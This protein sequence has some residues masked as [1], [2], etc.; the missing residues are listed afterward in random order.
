MNAR[1]EFQQVSVQQIQA[2]LE[3]S[4]WTIG[5]KI[6]D[7]MLNR[8][9]SCFS[10]QI[11]EDI[12]NVQKNVGVSIQKAGQAI[13]TSELLVLPLLLPLHPKLCPNPPLHR[14]PS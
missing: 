8:S 12:N 5:P 11:A 1:N 13:S 10:S 4:D 2:C 7:L 3:E 6:K 9:L 14:H